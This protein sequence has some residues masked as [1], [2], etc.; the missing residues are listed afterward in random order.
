MSY[1]ER[2]NRFKELREAL[3]MLGSQP[4]IRSSLRP[5]A[6]AAGQRALAELRQAAPVGREEPVYEI[7]RPGGENFIVSHGRPSIRLFGSTL[8]DNWGAPEVE[9]IEGGMKFTILSNAPHMGILLDGSP[10]HTI[11][12]RPG[13]PISFFCYTLNMPVIFGWWQSYSIQHPGQKK[14]DFVQTALDQGLEEEIKMLGVR[15]LQE[16]KKPLTQFFR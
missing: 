14:S 2:L 3:I 1:E 7:P 5:I 16:V 9:A 10:E 6:E 11:P 13:Q 12:K 4:N 15:G 8:I